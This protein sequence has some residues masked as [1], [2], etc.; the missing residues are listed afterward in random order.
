[1]KYNHFYQTICLKDFNIVDFDI[2]IL[3]SKMAIPIW[4]NEMQKIIEIAMTILQKFMY[5]TKKINHFSEKNI[6]N[7]KAFYCFYEAII[8]FKNITFLH[9]TYVK[10]YARIAMKS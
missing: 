2:R 9:Q 7:N 1:M 8:K 10:K 5:Y 6:Q 4:P 3:K